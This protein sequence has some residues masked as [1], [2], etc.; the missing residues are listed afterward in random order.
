[1]LT[2]SHVKSAKLPIVPFLQGS[3]TWLVVEHFRV[4]LLRKSFFFFL[5]GSER[6]GALVFIKEYVQ[7]WWYPD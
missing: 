6:H 4:C 5:K 7:L 2:N 3:F 1:M